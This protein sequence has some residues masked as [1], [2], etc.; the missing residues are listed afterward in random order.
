VEADDVTKWFENQVA[1]MLA[2]KREPDSAEDEP[3][4]EL[5]LPTNVVPMTGSDRVS[6]AGA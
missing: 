2:Y 6:T 4:E 5:A 3:E 1:D